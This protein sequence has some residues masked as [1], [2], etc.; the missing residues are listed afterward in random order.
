[1]PALAC[2][3][4]LYASYLISSQKGEGWKKWW[5]CLSF[6]AMVAYY[7]E[8]SSK[9]EGGSSQPSSAVFACQK[10][11]DHI[12][13]GIGAF[14]IPLPKNVIQ[15]IERESREGALLWASM[16]GG[17]E[18]GLKKHSLKGVFREFVLKTL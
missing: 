9:N 2:E 7:S 17:P 18:E 12:Q 15:A 1:M 6:F 4:V 11:Q 3:A 8:Y 13:M 16:E 5:S 10:I 14:L